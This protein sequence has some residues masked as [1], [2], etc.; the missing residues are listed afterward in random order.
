MNSYFSEGF[1]FIKG[2]RWSLFYAFSSSVELFMWFFF[3]VILHCIN[4]FPYLA[5]ILKEAGS[6]AGVLSRR[7]ALSNSHPAGSLRPL[8]WD[9]MGVGY[10]RNWGKGWTVTGGQQWS[11]EEQV[12]E[13]F[14]GFT[15]VHWRHTGHKVW[16]KQESSGSTAFTGAGRLWEEQV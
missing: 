11:G 15:L 12:L 5:C 4:R 9:R 14:W 6:R 7:V 10:R 3:L 13:V 16:E 2:E 1:L 8:C